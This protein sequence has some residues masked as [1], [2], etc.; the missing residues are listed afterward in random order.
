MGRPRILPADSELVRMRDEG[1]THQ[2]I[3][4]TVSRRTGTHIGRSTVSVALVRAGEADQRVR[5][6]DTV[7]WKV[8]HQHTAEYPLRMLRMLGRVRHGQPVN[9]D[10]HRR[11]KSW[12]AKL[13]TEQLVVAYCPTAPEGEGGFHYI[14]VE[15]KDHNDPN[16]PIRKQPVLPEEIG[17]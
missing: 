17:L 12:A 2:Q 15:A 16:L 3:A 6:R 1:M 13:S 11:L 14:P 8:Q 5:Y 9:E 4:D 7:P 10:E